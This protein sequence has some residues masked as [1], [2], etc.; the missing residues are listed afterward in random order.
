M[1]TLQFESASAANLAIELE[2]LAKLFGNPASGDVRADLRNQHS[3]ALY[4][5]N[6]LQDELTRRADAAEAKWVNETPAAATEPDPAAPAA[7]TAAPAKKRGRPSKV[8]HVPPQVG[9]EEAAAPAAAEPATAPT[10]EPAPTA[11]A[12][13]A[14][15]AANEPQ[16]PPVADP[17]SGQ[18]P[19][20]EDLLKLA[21]RLFSATADMNLV[22][23]IT[24]DIVCTPHLSSAKPEHYGPL[25][26]AFTTK[27]A[28]VGQLKEA[29]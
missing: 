15:K 5:N 26:Q 28:E 13:E 10:Q 27:L 19:T 11:E 9:G 14:A 17:L 18:Q 23:G 21:T 24:K 25:H 22:Q 20:L 3:L 16:T 29:A 12:V 1:I 4:S 6:E 7:E 2:T 8:T